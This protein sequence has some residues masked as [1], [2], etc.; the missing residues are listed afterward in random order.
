M[1]VLSLKIADMSVDV[2]D[3]AWQA[4]KGNRILPRLFQRA[5]LFAER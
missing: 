4:G 5:G 3:R 1:E 2:S